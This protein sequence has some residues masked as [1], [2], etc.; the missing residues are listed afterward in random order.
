MWK[1]ENMYVHNKSSRN[2]KRIAINIV[3]VILPLVIVLII[4]ATAKSF[5]T[6]SVAWA[7]APANLSAGNSSANAPKISPTPTQAIPDD[8]FAS[9]TVNGITI[10]A[11]NFKVVQSNE[12]PTFPN[13]T[14]LTTDVCFDLP[15]NRD[16]EDYPGPTIVNSKQQVLKPFSM[17]AIEVRWPPVM[18]NGKAVQEILDLRAGASGTPYE[19]EAAPGRTMG[20]RCETWYYNLPSNYDTSHFILTVASIAPSP[21]EGELCSDSSQYVQKMQEALDRRGAGIKI[22]GKCGQGS[23]GFEVIGK[24]N[25]MTDQQAYAILANPDFHVDVFGIRG[26]W[27]LEGGVR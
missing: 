10:Y 22:R 8:S 27:V 14:F 4:G 9:S 19:R 25:G 18:V 5:V 15:D 16:W 7:A 2:T 20:Q 3:A 6:N 12:W 23:D 24:P 11:G 17:D 21:R 1:G 13:G 26:P